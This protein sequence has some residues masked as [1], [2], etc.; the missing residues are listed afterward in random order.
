MSSV[1][2]ER[3][4]AGPGRGEHFLTH[5]VIVRPSARASLALVVLAL[6][7]LPLSRLPF[8]GAVAT[9]SIYAAGV[10][11]G[12]GLI[13]I[14]LFEEQLL[15]NSDPRLLGLAGTFLALMAIGAVWAAAGSL[16]VLQHTA[17][18]QVSGRIA[19][20]LAL[21]LGVG[22]SL[23]TPNRLWRQ[24]ERP[25]RS[26]ALAY[27]GVVG[28]MAVIVALAA[29]TA[30]ALSATGI[31]RV[32]LEHL[33][34]S[35]AVLG[36]ATFGASTAMVGAAWG[37]WRHLTQMQQWA[38]PT[39][40]AAMCGLLMTQAGGGA[41]SLGTMLGR[42]ETGMGLLVFILALGARLH[43]QDRQQLMVELSERRTL[44][45]LANPSET[46][47][48][49][50][51]VALRLC[52]ELVHLRG[53]AIAQVISL[54]GTGPAIPLVSY[55][56]PASGFPAVPYC[57]LPE[58]RTTDMRERALG[59]PWIERCAEA[60]GRTDDPALKE[61]WAAFIRLGIHAFAY[62]PIRQGNRVLGILVTGTAAPDGEAA[63][64][65][66]TQ[67]LPTLEDFAA[68]AASR[69]GA[70][71]I[72][73]SS[74]AEGAAV[75]LRHLNEGTHHPVFQ[76]IVDML[77]GRIHGY[78]ALT[79]FDG[80]LPPDRVFGIAKEHGLL[81]KLELATLD[82]AVRDGDQLLTKGQ[83]LSV[84]MSPEVLVEHQDLLAERLG[85]W[86]HG[87]VVEVTEHDAIADYSTVRSAIARLGPSTKLSVDDAGAGYASLRHILELRPDYVKLDI[88]L[89]QAML[90]DQA[91]EA[92]VAGI[93]H[94]AESSGCAL[95]AEGVETEAER[96]H[97][98]SLGIRMGQGYLFARP[99]PLS[100]LRRRNKLEVAAL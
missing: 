15:D 56:R 87:A 98:L 67:V 13:A 94:F 17:V 77:T 33:T 99:K 60:A 52:R 44:R 50:D 5:L 27:A 24:P 58:A 66:L 100:E 86:R 91:H 69:L 18:G 21:G 34:G 30:A 20:H 92:M 81:A 82:R 83:Y 41:L 84:N 47:E 93:Q 49:V 46:K 76:P 64:R 65:A 97:L 43:S 53:T 19:W 39:A 74:S 88:Y 72:S 48:S 32:Q 90:I 37:R 79:R 80:G 11:T 57:G 22:L 9:Q 38:L 26:T 62:A 73:T 63:T 2:S 1:S 31:P 16:G 35:G 45:Q 40:G 54:S 14:L 3:S 29:I 61:Y 8:P 12:C 95:V 7:L 10:A 42:I 28:M 36:W 25:G 68:V 89:V 75:V 4:R 78:E 55:P 59:A 6:V 85:Q 70:L 23:A 71:L 96:R 51:R